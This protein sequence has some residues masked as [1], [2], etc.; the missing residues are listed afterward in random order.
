[1]DQEIIYCP[2]LIIAGELHGC[3][4]E[5]SCKCLEANCGFYSCAQE[6]CSLP[7]I[8]DA[9]HKMQYGG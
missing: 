7:V 4:N 8:A 9:V 6:D 1:M 2:L 3:K 5:S